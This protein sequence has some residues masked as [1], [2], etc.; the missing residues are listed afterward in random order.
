MEIRTLEDVM[1]FIDWLWGKAERKQY[2][3]FDGRY[4]SDYGS[5]NLTSS[6]DY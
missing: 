3:S 5:D 2:L 4:Y 6:G 1:Q